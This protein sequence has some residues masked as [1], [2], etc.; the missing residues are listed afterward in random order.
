VTVLQEYLIPLTQEFLTKLSIAVP[1]NSEAPLDPHTVKRQV[2]FSNMKA[3]RPV[4]A[5]LSLK[6]F[7][8]HDREV[9]RFYCV[10]DDRASAYGDLRKMIVHYYLSDGTME[11]KESLLPNS[12]RSTSA[13]FL[14]RGKL[15]KKPELNNLS[16]AEIKMDYF[17]ASDLT[18]GSVIHLYGRPFV[19]CDCD[20]FTKAYYRKNHDI[21]SFDPV[22]MAEFSDE[23]PSLPFFE[24]AG[25]A[26]GEF[27]T[28]NIGVE[29]NEKKNFKKLLAYDGITLRFLAK[30]QSKNLVDQERTFVVSFQLA[31]YSISIFEPK[32]RNNGVVG[33]KFLDNR[34]IK[35]PNS[36]EYFGSVDF[37][38][39]MV[40]FNL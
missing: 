38:I 26:G 4:E 30:L 25:A 9:L 2:M 21:Q 3:T 36:T 15:A 40:P 32:G 24:K 23:E 1:P 27:S 17:T 12:G 14:R 37:F 39:G 13:L 29:S 6:Q 35:K 10:W 16:T 5:D 31:S 34:R 8:E 33:G 20:E 22:N 18:I 7:M 19:I 11:I 28:A